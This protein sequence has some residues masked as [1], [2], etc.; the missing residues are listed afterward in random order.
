MRERDQRIYYTEALVLWLTTSYLSLMCTLMNQVRKREERE[1]DLYFFHF[2]RCIGKLDEF[3]LLFISRTYLTSWSFSNRES[4]T[5]LHGSPHQVSLSLFS[6]SNLLYDREQLYQSMMTENGIGN[7]VVEKYS[8]INQS[9]V[10]QVHLYYRFLNILRLL[11][12]NYSINEK[13]FLPNIINFAINQIYSTVANVSTVIL[14]YFITFCLQRELPEVKY[15][16]YELLFQLLL[17]NW[18]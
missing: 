14:K 13:A 5:D 12:Q 2:Q 1:R 11:V 7:K 17:N 3:L 9:I 16:L 4:D 8:M 10:L 6:L 15:A 18:R